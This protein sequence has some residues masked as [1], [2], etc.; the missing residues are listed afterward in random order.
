MVR[1]EAALPER[2]KRAILTQEGIRR[3]INTSEVYP[4]DVTDEI[5]SDF[6]QKLLNSGYDQNFRGE[7]LASIRAGYQKIGNHFFS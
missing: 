2:T 4:K 6:M 7:I 3:L 1:A 5:L